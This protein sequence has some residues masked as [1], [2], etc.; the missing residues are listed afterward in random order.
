MC[1]DCIIISYFTC[2]V[3]CRRRMK[4]EYSKAYMDRVQL[5]RDA[6][7]FKHTVKAPHLA[8]F[9]TWKIH[10]S[11]FS[12]KEALYDYKKMTK[13]VCDFVERYD[14]DAHADLGTRNPMRVAEGMGEGCGY[15]FDPQSEGINVVDKVF[16]EPEDYKLCAQD[17]DKFFL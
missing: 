17:V 8:Q 6:I 13:L 12:F 7:D 9:Y 14:F 4:M 15:I 10:D 5:F 11:E 3:F 2:A 1:R 16:M